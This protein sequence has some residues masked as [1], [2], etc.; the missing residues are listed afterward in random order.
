MGYPYS[1]IAS[2]CSGNNYSN[3]D[4]V[5]NQS[6][7]MNKDDDNNNKPPR[8]YIVSVT[9]IQT[10]LRLLNYILQ[11]AL[12]RSAKGVDLFGGDG[13]KILS[14]FL[15]FIWMIDKSGK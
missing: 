3:T 12:N 10:S 8:Y 7:I 9:M 5:L 2:V 1:K 15:V 11:T 4:H 13:K 14:I 6:Q